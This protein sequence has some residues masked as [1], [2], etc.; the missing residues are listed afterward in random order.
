M[1]WTDVL[2][3]V[4][5]IVASLAVIT[6]GVINIGG[7][8]VIWQRSLEG[9]RLH[10]KYVLFLLENRIFCRPNKIHCAF[11]KT[12]MG[13][14]FFHFLPFSSQYFFVSNYYLIMANI[15]SI[16]PISQVRSIEYKNLFDFML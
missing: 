4:L 14:L 9:G 11:F 7:F 10:V 8:G 5:M 6:L 16:L 15:I 12:F 1:V 13:E 3:G 2:Q